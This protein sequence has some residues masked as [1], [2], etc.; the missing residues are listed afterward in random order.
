MALINEW[1][2]V[3][4]MITGLGLFFLFFGVIMFFDRALLAFGNLL[5]VAGVVLVIGFQKTAVFFFQQRKL[6]GTAC[7]LLGIVLV[8]FRWPFI[9]IAIEVFGF[10]NLFGDFF[11][12]ILSFLRQMP[13]IGSLLNMP[14]IAQVVDRIVTQGRLPV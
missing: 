1:Q 10:F 5:F 9:G 11:P 3:G 12:I 7:F 14:Y 8:L 2:R 4:I 13:I 6:K